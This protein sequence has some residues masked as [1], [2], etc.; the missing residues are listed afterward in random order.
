MM[1]AKK[2]DLRANPFFLDDEAV[3]WVEETYE[4]MTMHERIC[5]LFVDPLMNMNREELLAFL[6]KYPIAGASF[7]GGQFPIEETQDILRDIQGRMKIPMLISSDT[8]AGANFALRNGTFIATAA[9][10]GAAD[11]PEVAYHVTAAAATEIAAAGYNWSFGAL[12]DIYMNWRNC[13][14]NT[15]TYGDN[16]EDVIR[17]CEGFIRGFQENRMVTCLKHFPGDGW[18]ERDQ[19]IVICNNGLSCEEWDDTFGKIYRHFIDAGVLSIM[20]GHFTLPAYQRR[21]NPELADRDMLPAPLSPELI[22]GLLR[23]KLGFNGL[24]FTDQTRMLG[25]AAMKRT[26][27]VVQSIVAGLD[28]VLGINDIEEDVDA[29]RRGIED[30]RITPE[31]LREA[32]CRTLATKAAIGLHVKQREGRLVPGPEAL[33]VVGCEKFKKWAV[34]ASDAAITLVKDTKHQLPIRPE[35]HRRLLVNFLGGE[36][37][38]SLLGR[39]VASGGESGARENVRQAL[40]KAGFEVTM[41]EETPGLRSKGKTREFAQKYDAALI[42]ADFTAFA[43]ISSVRLQWSAP[44][45]NG[46]PWY[47]PEIPTAF[48]SLNYTNHMADVPRVPIFINAYNDRPYTIELLVKKL[49]GDSPFRGKYNDTVWCGMWDT[50]F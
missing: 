15:R 30:G 50:R 43:T 17:G 8:E 7:R 3:R 9:Q 19:H 23:E 48:I 6:E 32:V 25:Y 24:V 13:L 29:M 42:F 38:G 34:E 46:A 35:T 45:S 14:V 2:M 18:E 33:S 5:Q 44:M 4:S 11:D 39:G 40:E 20:V 31:R 37:T 28:I 21:L 22:T 26:D 47:E 10:A 12:G 49:M 1:N 27:A 36:L 41:Y 16:A